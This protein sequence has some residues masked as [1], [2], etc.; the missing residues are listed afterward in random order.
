MALTAEQKTRVA[1]ILQKGKSLESQVA[2]L[3]GYL[4]SSDPDPV[5]AK[6]RYNSLAALYKEYLKYNDE[7]VQLDSENSQLTDFLEVE[8]RY[9]DVASAVTKLQR[10]EPIANSTLN[11]SNI[12]VTE[13]QDL[14]RLP[15]IKL[16]MFNGKRDEWATYKNK[17]ISLVHS[18]TDLSDA[19]KCS[20]L[21]ASLTDKALETIAHYDPSEKD[22]KA[23]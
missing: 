10:I 9:F 12:T 2:K 19:V 22:C 11:A 20:H 16:P 18:R 21:F 6:M 15:E 5:N 13:R 23:A 7:L 14:P 4:K 8:S 3:E 17:F 1:Y